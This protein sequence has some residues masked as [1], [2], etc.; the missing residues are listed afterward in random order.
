LP[1]PCL[2]TD[3][4]T[5]VLLLAGGS[6]SPELAAASGAK[7]RCLITLGGKTLLERMLESIQPTISSPRVVVN[8]GADDTGKEFLSPLGDKYSYYCSGGN[9]LEAM[10]EG[11]GIFKAEQGD[12]A[13]EEQLLLV[14]V[15][16]PL[17]SASQLGDLIDDALALGADAVWPIVEK[18]IVQSQFPDTKRTYIRTKQGTFTGGN[19]FMLRPRIIRDNQAMI[20]KAYQ[21]RKNPLALASLFSTSVLMRVLSGT[22]SIPDLEVEFSQRFKANLRLLPFRHPA[23]AVDLD[24]L[25]DYE[26]MKRILG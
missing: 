12:G 26:M 9:L 8:L 21:A 14:N 13:F 10:N 16:V 1:G 6:V 4:I 7:K 18:G 20:D 11:I 19:I 3:S 23:V 2:N 17:I 5:N 25:S 15:D 24:K 22:I